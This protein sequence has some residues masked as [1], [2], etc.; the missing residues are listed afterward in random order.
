MNNMNIKV[1]VTLSF[2]F[3]AIVAIIAMSF[4]YII[5]IKREIVEIEQKVDKIYSV[6]NPDMVEVEIKIIK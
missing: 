2:L 5:I 1:Y 3:G 4:V 6:I